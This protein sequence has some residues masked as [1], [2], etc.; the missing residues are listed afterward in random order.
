MGKNNNNNNQQHRKNPKNPDPMS[1]TR[2]MGREGM[3]IIHNIAFGSFNI[4]NDGHIFRNLDFVK[5]TMMEVNKRLTDA[6]IHMMAIEFAYAGCNDPAVLNLLH[7]DRKSVEAYCLINEC[8]GNIVMSSGDTGF[9]LV[10]ANKLPQ[11][12]Y[13]I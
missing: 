13:N 9:L 11:F 4:F 5:A 8:L 6:R 1:N 3:K 12:K 7:R 2:T 10:L